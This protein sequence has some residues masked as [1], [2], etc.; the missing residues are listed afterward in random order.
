MVIQVERT[1]FSQL[2][3]ALQ[4]MVIELD[5]S[6][7]PEWV[8]NAGFTNP[9]QQWCTRSWSF[10]AVRASIV[11]GHNVFLPRFVGAAHYG[12]TSDSGMVT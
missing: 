8:G 12:R 2:V 7:F 4:I 1:T 10:D 6:F 9:S 11:P 3:T 5:E